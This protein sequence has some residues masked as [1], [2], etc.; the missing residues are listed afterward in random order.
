MAGFGN[1]MRWI[2]RAAMASALLLTSGSDSAWALRKTP[3]AV[4]AQPHAQL[5][6]AAPALKNSP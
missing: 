3:D 6:P 4:A 5:A 2:A 1:S